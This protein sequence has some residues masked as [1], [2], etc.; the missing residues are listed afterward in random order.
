MV[1]LIVDYNPPQEIFLSEIHWSCPKCSLGGP[2]R[3]HT[4]KQGCK[5]SPEKIAEAIGRS[6]CQL[7]H[8]LQNSLMNP[9]G[10]AKT[11]YGEVL[12]SVTSWSTHKLR[13]K[14][15]LDELKNYEDQ[16]DALANKQFT[17]E[18]KKCSTMR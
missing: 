10:V 11:E 13:L 2:E 7:H 16:L 12:P 1:K 4:R 14:S 18:C 6:G 9:Y 17:I 8:N 15:Q 5:Y 3:E